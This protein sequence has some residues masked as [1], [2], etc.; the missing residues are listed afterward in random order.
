[1]NQRYL[2]PWKR[3]DAADVF[4]RTVHRYVR[5]RLVDVD[6]AYCAVEASGWK[7]YTKDYT[8]GY[9]DRLDNKY[10]TAKTAEEA[11]VEKDKLLLADGFILLT[12]EQAEKLAVLI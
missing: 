7:G 1:V 12:K 9:Y 3:E 2:L 6:K 8:W 10:L 11:M 5:W 4:D